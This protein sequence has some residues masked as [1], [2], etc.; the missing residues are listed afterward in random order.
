MRT[1]VCAVAVAFLFAEHA[2]AE[3]CDEAERGTYLSNVCWLVNTH[4]NNRI[5]V[6]KR[7]IAE[8]DEENCTITLVRSQDDDNPMKIYFNRANLRD[9]ETRVVD[10]RNC[11]NL[12]GEKL[13][14]EARGYGGHV[15][16]CGRKS[17]ERVEAAAVNLYTEYCTG[18]E[19]EF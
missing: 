6:Y 7:S 8:T 3:P 15:A 5:F 11:L 2:A 4:A 10:G 1:L 14:E 17:I 12:Y 9:I 16:F 18:Q 19:S 13:V